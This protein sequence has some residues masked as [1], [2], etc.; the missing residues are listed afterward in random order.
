MVAVTVH[1]GWGHEGDEALK[2][3][4]GREDDLGAAA[5]GGFWGPIEEPRVGRGEGGDAGKGVEA[6]EREG[7]PG[8]VAEEPFDAG[9]VVAFACAPRHRC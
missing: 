6:F 5:G 8:T 4:E 3:F 7:R 9:A 2:E 1:P